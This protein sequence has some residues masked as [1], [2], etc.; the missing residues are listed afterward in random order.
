MRFS[1]NRISMPSVSLGLRSTRHLCWMA[2]IPPLW[3]SAAHAALVPTSSTREI[4][5]SSD[6]TSA[7]GETA[8]FLDA[9]TA[10]FPDP[11]DQHVDHVLVLDTIFG[12]T[13]ASQQDSFFSSSLFS[14]SGT[15]LTQASS[16]DP[17]SVA[18]FS[19]LSDYTTLFG[20]DTT[21]TYR[22][23][24]SVRHS[25]SAFPN[26][27][28]DAGRA[29]VTLS[30]L[31]GPVIFSQEAATNSFTPFEQSFLLEA[32]VVYELTAGA[33]AFANLADPQTDASSSSGF[34][35]LLAIPEPTTASLLALGLLGLAMRR[36]G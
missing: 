9:A 1:I 26:P 15:T 19:A 7:S 13:L 20:V 4:S 3:F 17:A 25:G 36:R 22:I 29:I 12:T 11:F 23:S 30:V 24:G 34:T 35:F 21:A 33:S 8:S 31:G 18:A 28:A 16:S 6:A 5:I 32:A 27:P 14:A 2:L 10:T